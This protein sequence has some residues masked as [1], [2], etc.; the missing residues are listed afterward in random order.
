[1]DLEGD[2]AIPT[3]MESA[4]NLVDMLQTLQQDFKTHQL[5]IVD[6]TNE[7]DALADEQQVLE[8]SDDQV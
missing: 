1:M 6:R 8:N 3:F 4:R 7:E 2:T 5:T